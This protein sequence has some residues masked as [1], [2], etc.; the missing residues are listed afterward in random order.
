MLAKLQSRLPQGIWRRWLSN[1]A[2]VLFPPACTICH[3]EIEETNDPILICPGCRHKVTDSRHPCP[4]CG[5]G[6]ADGVNPNDR[7]GHC[8]RAKFNF[9]SVVRLGEYD[10]PL[11]S[12]ILRAKHGANAAVA[13]HMGRLLAD[14]RY[15]EFFGLKAEVIIAVPAFWKRRSNYGHNSADVLAAAIAD[16]LRVPLGEHLVVRTRHTRPQTSLTPSERPANVRNAFATRFHPDLP[17]AHVLIVDDVLTT[18]ATCNEIAKTLRN[19]GAAAVSVAVLA[20]A[21]GNR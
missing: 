15:T 19:A 2:D 20:R 14:V 1:A 13:M 5:A 21:V 9:S 7:C 18:G 10:G 4:A 6:L 11:Q 12:A 17:G 8:R 3:C 16:R